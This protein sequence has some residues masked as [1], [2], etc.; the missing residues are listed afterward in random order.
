MRKPHGHLFSSREQS[1]NALLS[2]ILGGIS[3]LSCSIMVYLTYKNGGQAQL[4]YGGVVFICLFFSLAGMILAILSR[5]E[6]EL[7]LAFGFVVM[8]LGA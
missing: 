8:Y 3:L 4:R 1:V 5:R 7:V 6:P 2:V